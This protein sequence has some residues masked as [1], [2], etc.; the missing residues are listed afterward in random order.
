[1]P[2]CY[3]SVALGFFDKTEEYG[4]NCGK[5]SF[6]LQNTKGAIPEQ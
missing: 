4:Y 5:V 3:F 2:R 6:K 1:M